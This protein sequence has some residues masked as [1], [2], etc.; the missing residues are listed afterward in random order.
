MAAKPKGPIVAPRPA[1]GTIG[2]RGKKR[3]KKKGE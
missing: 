2:G 3:E 1:P